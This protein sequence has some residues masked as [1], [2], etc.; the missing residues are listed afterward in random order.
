MQRIFL[1]LVWAVLISLHSCTPKYQRYLGNYPTVDAGIPNYAD[2]DYWAAH[3]DKNDPSDS[4]PAPLRKSYR[5]DSTVDVFFLHPTTFTGKDAP[6]WNADISDAPL[7]AKTDYSTILYQASAFNEYRVFAPRYRQAHLRSYYSESEEASNAF[8]TA[9]HD[10]K[11]AFIYYLENYN[12]NRP[13]VIASHSQGTTHA[14]RLLREFRHNKTVAEKLVVAYLVGMYIPNDYSSVL[15]VCKDSVDVGCLCG[16]RSFQ[17]DY[18]PSYVEGEKKQSLVTNPLTWR[19]DQSYAPKN[20]N[21]GSVLRNFNKLYP[22]VADARIHKGVLW[23]NRPR[24]PGSFFLRTKNYHIADI[25]FFY[26]N[27]RENLHSRVATF[28]S[29][30]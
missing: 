9:Y 13:F 16:W 21:K 24:F 4:V 10:I 19:A 8:D 1:L 27:I 28:K 18:L 3:P 22:A 12:H 26:M 29:R 14:L 7:N 6:S 11:S 20:L 2:V 5:F 25:N 23:I 15:P 17:T 30:Q